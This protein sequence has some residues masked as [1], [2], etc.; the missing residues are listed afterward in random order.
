MHALRKI[1]R[2]GEW[3]FLKC[4]ERVRAFDDFFARAC[5]LFNAQFRRVQQFALTRPRQ[6]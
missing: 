1:N 4:R 6:W 3:R 2:F 5:G